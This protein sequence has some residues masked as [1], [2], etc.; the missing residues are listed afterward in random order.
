MLITRKDR[1]VYTTSIKMVNQEVKKQNPKETAEM[2]LTLAKID[3]MI[4]EID[5]IRTEPFNQ[6]ELYKLIENNEDGNPMSNGAEW[7]AR[8]MKLIKETFHEIL[9]SSNIPETYSKHEK[10][11]KNV[12][13]ENKWTEKM[14]F[15]AVGWIET[16]SQNTWAKSKL[17]KRSGSNIEAR[18]E[19]FETKTKIASKCQENT[20]LGK[21]QNLLGNN[22][23]G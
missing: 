10:M 21:S 8:T 1:N 19:I 18:M 4:S 15:V 5:T 7:R 20:E 17:T 9:F 16:D 14:E 11:L 23:E 13:K 3:I 22:L 2:G 12:L 6:R